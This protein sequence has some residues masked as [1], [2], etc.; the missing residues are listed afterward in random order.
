M[1]NVVLSQIFPDAANDA[2]AGYAIY[3]QL[4][5]LTRD[6]P[7]TDPRHYSFS[8]VNGFVLDHLGISRWVPHNP[9]Y[10]PGPPPPPK[11]S[12]DLKERKKTPRAPTSSAVSQAT[13]SFQD[14]VSMR[15][16]EQGPLLSSI[17]VVPAVNSRAGAF[18]RIP[19]NRPTSTQRPQNHS[20]DP[21]QHSVTTRIQ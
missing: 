7:N 20:Y 1:L 6:V 17:P 13:A 2:R 19:R 3:A 5:A 18:H 14:G 21:A 15:N 11:E 16:D 9:Y 4:I 12:K 10:D 8:V